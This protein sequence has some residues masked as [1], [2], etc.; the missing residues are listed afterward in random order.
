MP[1]ARHNPKVR[2]CPVRRLLKVNAFRKAYFFRQAIVIALAMHNAERKLWWWSGR[3]QPGR[4]SGTG[5]VGVGAGHT[6]RHMGGVAQ[7]TDCCSGTRG[8]QTPRTLPR[9]CLSKRQKVGDEEA[10]RAV[11]KAVRRKAKVAAAEQAAEEA[12]G[13]IADLDR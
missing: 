2:S 8:R 5:E 7:P 11:P 9:G 1:R 13:T 6:A 10:P 3:E 12:A 4:S